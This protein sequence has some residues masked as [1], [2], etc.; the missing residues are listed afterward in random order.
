[1]AVL[2]AWAESAASLVETD[3]MLST[4][5]ACFSSRYAASKSLLPSAAPQTRIRRYSIIAV[6][7]AAAVLVWRLWSLS[8]SAQKYFMIHGRMA[9]PVCFLTPFEPKALIAEVS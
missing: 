5:L 7:I 9:K 2:A 1:M 8:S 6:T 3:L 4:I